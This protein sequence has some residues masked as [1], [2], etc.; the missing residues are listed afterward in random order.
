MLDDLL[1]PKSFPRDLMGELVRKFVKKGHDAEPH[2][3][4]IEPHVGS[5]GSGGLICWD[6][7]YG[8]K[9][10]ARVSTRRATLAILGFRPVERG[11]LVE[12][13]QAQG[14]KQS[15]VRYLRWERLLVSALIEL[16]RRGEVYREVQIQAASTTTWFTEPVGLCSVKKEGGTIQWLL[17]GS[18]T[19]EEYQA[20]MK[21]RYDGTARGL[22]FK[23][24]EDKKLWI[25]PLRSG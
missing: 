22:G 10:T 19:L 11:F 18:R 8:L 24:C 17:E 20:D 16:A 14:D 25:Y 15:P 23:W 4:V 5:I 12:Q 3:F 7:R 2:D 9:L 1:S 13:L 6:T 21:R